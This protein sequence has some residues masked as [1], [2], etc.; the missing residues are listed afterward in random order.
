MDSFGLRNQNTSLFGIKR[1]YSSY[2]SIQDDHFACTRY[3]ICSRSMDASMFLSKKA[4]SRIKTMQL[5]VLLYNRFNHTSSGKQGCSNECET[6]LSHG[7]H[8]YPHLK[9]KKFFSS[10]WKKLSLKQSMHRS[11]GNLDSFDHK[12]SDCLD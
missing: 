3:S 9:D 11:G 7:G 12:W 10:L 6:H 4:T 2:H 1:I 5:K 8:K